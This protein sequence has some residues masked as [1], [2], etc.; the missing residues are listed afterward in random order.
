[1]SQVDDEQEDHEFPYKVLVVGDSGTGKTSYI[2]SFVH[3]IFS[4]KYKSTIG[5]DFAL[6]V[7]K[8]DEKVVRLQLWDIAGQERYGNL[9][10]VY[11]NG[12]A[13]AFVIFDVTRPN[14]FENA[15]KWKSDIDSKVYLSD[16]SPISVVLLANKI[17]LGSDIFEKTKEDMD[18]ICQEFGFIGWFTTSAK[19]KEN[20]DES[21]NFLV[22]KILENDQKIKKKEERNDPVI[23]LTEFKPRPKKKCSK[24]P[25]SKKTKQ[26][27]N[28]FITFNTFFYLKDPKKKRYFRRRRN[29]SNE[30]TSVHLKNV[31]GLGSQEN[32]R[33]KRFRKR[34]HK[35]IKLQSLKEFPELPKMEP[36]AT[37]NTEVPILKPKHEQ[38]I[39]FVSVF[40]GNK[41]IIM[42]QIDE[43][44]QKRKLA[45]P[46]PQAPLNYLEAAQCDPNS[47][48]EISNISHLKK[49]NHS[50]NFSI[51]ELRKRKLTEMQQL[52]GE[53]K[54]FLH[55]NNNHNIRYIKRTSGRFIKL[56]EAFIQIEIRK[57][58]AGNWQEIIL[59]ALSS[60]TI[61]LRNPNQPTTLHCN[62]CLLSAENGIS[63]SSHSN[64]LHKNKKNKHKLAMSQ[65]I[66]EKILSKKT[67]QKVIPGEICDV[68]VDVRA[69]RDFAGANVVK[70][71]R[72][73]GLTIEDNKRTF[74]TFDCNPTGSDMNYANNQQ[75]CRVFARERG[76]K[77]FDIDKGIG[78]HI[79][80]DEKVVKPGDVF[81]S[82]DSH[83]NI[84]GAICAFGQGMG[85]MDIA[86]AWTRGK[87][88]FKIPHSVKVNLKGMPGKYATPKDV[89]LRILQ[90]LGANSLLGYSAEIYGEYID[91]L[92]LS[93]RITIASMATEMG[94]II[95]LF[96]PNESIFKELGFDP[97]EFDLS[98]F[99]ADPNAKY[100]KEFD[101][102]ITN[103]GP[104]ISR[105]GHPEDVVAVKDLFNTKIDSCILGSC[106]NGRYEDLKLAADIIKGNQVAP[107]VILKV[108]PSTQAIYLRCLREGIIQIFVEAGALVSNPGCSSCAAGQVGMTGVN[109]IT[110]STGNRNFIGKQGKGKVF[111]CSPQTV[112]ASAISGVMTT[113]DNILE[114][115][116]L[117]PEPEKNIRQIDNIQSQ[118]ENCAQPQTQTQTQTQQQIQTQDSE[119]KEIAKPTQ[120]T[121]RVWVIPKDN[122]DTD[123]IFHNKH[124][125]ITDINQMGQYAFGNLEGWTD[126][127]KNAKK[128][129]IILTGK[130]FGCGSSRQQAV[131]CFINL[132]ISVIIAQ[133]FGAIYERNA[134]NAGLP[135][136]TL[137]VLDLK[138]L[139]ISDAD[140][141]SVDLI[142]GNILNKRTNVVVKANPCSKTQL[143]IYHRGG[144]L[145]SG[146][147]SQSLN[148]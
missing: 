63:S 94:A 84:M 96:P 146:V 29:E 57:N 70:N 104:L 56:T 129:D 102:D 31:V 67:D 139:D 119:L 128:G 142:N 101:I 148:W 79:V 88:W 36:I 21:V 14:T 118:C 107:G 109:E 80:I 136:L 45:P 120:F 83:A 41:E 74:F 28:F 110:L 44:P 135:I 12:A 58:S 33:K 134:I 82:T 124:L 50:S 38:N 144:L 25:K 1:M 71:I 42:S 52:G 66:I 34:N 54:A 115:P 47:L 108:V 122:I 30:K 18:N 133:S 78:T 113:V 99:E 77:V 55:S 15:K 23:N 17:D 40:F 4:T 39:K 49:N 11:Y 22:K 76:I 103:I 98:L 64:T 59:Y 16:G 86:A 19:T 6:K 81:V 51:P 32:R 137:P 7:M 100:E 37:K 48:Q 10:R 91:T 130:N 147:K 24:K 114:K 73:N 43:N 125:T 61:P 62:E 112:I 90:V 89:T 145:V 127:S 46:P 140:V 116:I 5:V 65:T 2:N 69:A 53:S 126:F 26:I 8:I 60:S 97:K 131:D 121:G 20:I 27:A 138:E 143:E 95:L 93:S 106:T 72:N 111:L 85:D 123:M 68:F 75:I 35:K 92:N 87:V 141:I 105:A 3:G 9:T 13:G 132:G 117:F